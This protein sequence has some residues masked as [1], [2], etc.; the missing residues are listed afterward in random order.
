VA[1]GLALAYARAPA[2]VLTAELT[3]VLLDDRPPAIGPAGGG[4][5]RSRAIALARALGS[6]D[7][8]RTTTGAPGM[9]ATRAAAQAVRPRPAARPMT[10]PTRRPTTKRPRPDPA[11]ERRRGVEIM[12]GLWADVARSR[13][14]GTGGAVGPRHGAA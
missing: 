13:L 1:V 14:A 11:V 5:P 10:T 7:G 12:L 9:P 4:R 3:R 8:S 2:A 6:G